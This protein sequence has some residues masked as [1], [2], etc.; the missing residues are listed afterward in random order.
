MLR[1]F[2]LAIVLSG[3]VAC[4]HTSVKSVPGPGG[5]MIYEAQCNGNRAT[6]A[7]CMKVAARTCG[8]KPYELLDRN[9]ESGFAPVHNYSTGETMYVNTSKK[10]MLFRCNG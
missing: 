2:V 5:E 10:Q 7:D 4:V 3:S 1:T 9:A 8:E 6:Y